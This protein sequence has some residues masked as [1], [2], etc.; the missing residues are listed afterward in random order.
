[1]AERGAPSLVQRERHRAVRAHRLLPAL[2]A[3]Q[4]RGVAPPVQEEEALLAPGEAGGERVAQ[5]RARGSGRLPP[6][7]TSRRSTI[8][9]RGRPWGPIRRGRRSRSYLPR[10]AFACDSTDGRRRAE[11]DRAALEP[12]PHHRHVAPVVA[13]ALVLLVGAVVLL[14]HDHEAEAG[15][16]RED[17]GAR[18]HHD[19]RLA[20]ANAPPLVVALA[21]RELAVE[22]GDG[23]PEAGPGGANEHRR[24]ADLG[25]EDDRAAAARRERPPPHGSTPRSSRCPSRR[26]GGRGGTFPPRPPRRAAGA[27]P[28]GRAS[29]RGA[30]RRGPAA[31]RA[32][33]RPAPRRDAGRLSRR[34]GRRLPAGR[35]GRGRGRPRARVRRPRA[36]ARRPRPGPGLS[37]RRQ[38]R[39]GRPRSPRESPGR[40][41]PARPRRGR[42]GGDGRRGPADRRPASSRSRRAGGGHRGARGA[43]G[44][45]RPRPVSFARRTT[46][47]LARTP[48][49]GST[50]R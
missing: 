36:A 33:A 31:P 29:A 50:A 18:A 6:R 14:V 10:S 24:E 38:R 30:R 9:T 17:R 4:A 49:G 3:E 28:P 40:R 21:G 35:G 27:P 5:G 43:P 26:G 22:D 2:A 12:R 1:M 20:L 15:N 16:G 11:H 32:I 8:S 25:D 47:R 41:G 42:P 45:P 34:A 19:A 48:A 37:A 13:G 44:P 39:P 46:V 23:R 7:S